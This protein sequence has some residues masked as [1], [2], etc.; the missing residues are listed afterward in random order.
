MKQRFQINENAREL[1]TY[2]LDDIREMALE[3]S[4]GQGSGKITGHAA[5]FNQ[6]IRMRMWGFEYDEVIRPGAFKRTID[7][8]SDVYGYWNHNSD[9]ILGRRKNQTLTIQEDSVGLA[10]E[11]LPPDTTEAQEKRELIRLGFVDKMSFG[12]SIKKYQWTE[13]DDDVD[14]L[15]LLELRL[16]E[17]SPVPFPAYTGTDVSARNVEAALRE[18]LGQRVNGTDE[19]NILPQTL[20]TIQ[21]SVEAG[22]DSGPVSHSLRVLRQRLNDLVT[23]I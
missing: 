19:T 11:L 8:G 23:R 3:E 13:R 9:I 2:D 6:P 22:G 1:R 7:N 4:E 15:E 18:M 12:F 14:L 5:V 16:F 21:E 17:I 20:E 10:F